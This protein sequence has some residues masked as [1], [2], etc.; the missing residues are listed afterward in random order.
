MVGSG[1]GRSVAAALEEG[2]PGGA[3][4]AAAAAAALLSSGSPPP[5]LG[6]A[7]HPSAEPARPNSKGGG[8]CR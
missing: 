2:L 3:A 6:S 7:P 5:C 4:A 1:P 8:G